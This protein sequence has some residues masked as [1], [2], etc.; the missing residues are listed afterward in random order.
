MEKVSFEKFVKDRRRQRQRRG[1]VSGRETH[2]G[3][4]LVPEERC[5]VIK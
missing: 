3:R 2:I 4:Q 1:L 5:S